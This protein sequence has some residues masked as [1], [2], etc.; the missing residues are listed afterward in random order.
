[1][2]WTSLGSCQSLLSRGRYQDVTDDS[3]I[4]T[5]RIKSHHAVGLTDELHG[6]MLR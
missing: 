4:R 5:I 6:H 2:H 3:D 1:M